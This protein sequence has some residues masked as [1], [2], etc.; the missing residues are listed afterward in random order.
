MAP[1]ISPA[2]RPAKPA[3]RRRPPSPRPSPSGRLR[4]ALRR[5]V[6]LNSSSQCMTFKLIIPYVPRGTGRGGGAAAAAAAAVARSPG[7]AGPGAGGGEAPEDALPDLTPGQLGLWRETRANV[8]RGRRELYGM[9]RERR[10]AR[11]IMEAATRYFEAA[12]DRLR[13]RQALH[14]RD[15]ERLR[16]LKS[17]SRFFS[18]FYP[19][20]YDDTFVGKTAIG[21]STPCGYATK[22]RGH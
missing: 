22:C 11:A 2:A 9:R 13:R 17:C 7:R 8:E 1:D 19:G 10:A 3:H 15:I 18:S 6:L 20:E 5:Q 14:R 16:A 21:S 12:S 4:R